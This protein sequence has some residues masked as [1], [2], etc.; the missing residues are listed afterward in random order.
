MSLDESKAARAEQV[1]RFFAG[2]Q[3]D[4]FP[5]IDLDG[6]MLAFLPPGNP[7]PESR[8]DRCR[9]LY[10]AVPRRHATIRTAFD[11]HGYIPQIHITRP[12]DPFMHPIR[13]LLRSEMNRRKLER[14]REVFLQIGEQATRDLNYLNRRPHRTGRLIPTLKKRASR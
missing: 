1:R 4:P 7:K 9:R 3:L 2:G 12:G 11:S 6:E 8:V 13:P 5:T 10:P 14:L